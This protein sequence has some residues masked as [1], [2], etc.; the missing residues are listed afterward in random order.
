[1]PFE[2]VMDKKSNNVSR[3]GEYAA[4]LSSIKDAPVTEQSLARF[5]DAKDQMLWTWDLYDMKPDGSVTRATGND[6]KPAVMTEYT[7]TMITNHERNKPRLRFSALY[8]RPITKD[9]DAQ[10]LADGAIGKKC[11]LWIG[12][13]PTSNGQDKLVIT[14]SKAYDGRHDQ[15]PS[16]PVQGMQ[17]LEREM[18]GAAAAAPSSPPGIGNMLDPE[19]DF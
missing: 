19:D 8:G 14:V 17:E 13:V 16:S 3:P 12:P 4:K 1:M 2:N 5:P 18:V 10:A 11:I 15:Q 9:D 6:G 7:N